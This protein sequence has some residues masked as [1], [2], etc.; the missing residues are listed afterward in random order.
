MDAGIQ[1]TLRVNEIRL[2]GILFCGYLAVSALK[3]LPLDCSGAPLYWGYG[4][5]RCSRLRGS[6]C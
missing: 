2:L 6:H 4:G 5:P 1:A 3:N